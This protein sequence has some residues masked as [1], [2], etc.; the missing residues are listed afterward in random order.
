MSGCSH[1]NVVSYFTSFVVRDELWLVMRLMS[2]GEEWLWV[3]IT[4]VCY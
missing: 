3:R 4:S 2:G 1:P